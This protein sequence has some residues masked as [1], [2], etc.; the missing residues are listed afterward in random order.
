MDYQM[1]I[2][3]TT[4]ECATCRGAVDNMGIINYRRAENQLDKDGKSIDEFYP[5]EVIDMESDYEKNGGFNDDG[6]PIAWGVLARGK[7][8]LKGGEWLVIE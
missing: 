1:H 3:N 7:K 6:Q 2:I 4:Y 5:Q 8:I